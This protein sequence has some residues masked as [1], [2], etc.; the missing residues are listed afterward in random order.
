MLPKPADSPVSVTAALVLQE[1]LFR[2]HTIHLLTYNFTTGKVAL[3]ALHKANVLV[4]F[5]IFSAS[6]CSKFMCLFAI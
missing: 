4:P 5:V 6:N 3:Y 1:S 2:T